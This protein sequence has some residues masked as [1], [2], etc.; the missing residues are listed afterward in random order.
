MMARLLGAIQFLTVLPI[1]GSTSPVS[2]AAIF[3]PVVGAALGCLAGLLLPFTSGYFGRPLAALLTIAFLVTITGALHEDGL[4]DTADAF[5]AGRTRDRILAI[6]RDSRIGAYGA[7]V[8]ILSLSIRWQALTLAPANP[9]PGLTAALGI[10][11]ASLVILAATTPAF[12]SGLGSGFASGLS[13][14]VLY[15]VIAQSIALAALAGW[16]RGC[17]M[18]AA[19]SLTLLL[20]RAYFLRRAGGI[21]GDCLG[22]TCQAVEAANFLVLAWHPS[23]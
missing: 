5:R 8:L 20:A 7:V 11:R 21:N 6:L 2:F 10:S 9:I 14:P 3:F 1:A 17:A 23:T 18:L 12:G 15:A 22:A 4:A 13:R 16:P 19:S